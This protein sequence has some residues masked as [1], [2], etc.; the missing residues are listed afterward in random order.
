MAVWYSLGSFGIFF[1]FWY[2]WSKKN[3]ATLMYTPYFI[4]VA[5][6]CTFVLLEKKKWNQVPGSLPSPYNFKKVICTPLPALPFT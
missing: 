6:N 3:L 1:P 5:L 4:L 2:V